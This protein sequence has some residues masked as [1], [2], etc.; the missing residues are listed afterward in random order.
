MEMVKFGYEHPV[1]SINQLVSQLA[2]HPVSLRSSLISR[3]IYRGDRGDRL[4]QRLLYCLD[5]S[6]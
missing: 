1:P 4:L 2:E 6:D 5:F 3:E